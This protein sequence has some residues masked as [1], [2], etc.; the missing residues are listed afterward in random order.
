[1]HNGIGVFGIGDMNYRRYRLLKFADKYK[2][3]IAN[4][5]HSHKNSRITT[6]HSPNGL[7]HNQI[8]YILATHRF[9]SSIIRS[10]MISYKIGYSRVLI[11]TVIMIS[12]IILY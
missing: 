2:L 3:V 9:K 12:D 4:T 6:R 8:Y 7:I 10:S 1:M 5:L 11:S